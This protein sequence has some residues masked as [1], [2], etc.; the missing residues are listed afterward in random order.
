MEIVD[1]KFKD[2][3]KRDFEKNKCFDFAPFVLTANRIQPIM[4]LAIR[5]KRIIFRK[6]SEVKD[7]KDIDYLVHTI[8][9]E[10]ESQK[11]AEYKTNQVIN[12]EKD[13]IFRFL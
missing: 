8:I 11:I 5:K 10:R 7:E 3:F 6:L 12:L 1:S 9:K 2:L 13:L 4:D